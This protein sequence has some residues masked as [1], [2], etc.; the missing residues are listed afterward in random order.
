MT[1]EHLMAYLQAGA[2]I[3]PRDRT[4]PM[5]ERVCAAMA[6]KSRM[7]SPELVWAGKYDEKGELKPADRTILPFQ[8]VETVNESKADREK[9]QR[10]IFTKQAED[11]QWRIF[12]IG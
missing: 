8:V 7:R 6:E 4:E 2:R 3:S 1:W 9:A 10:D 11:S 12:G 5:C